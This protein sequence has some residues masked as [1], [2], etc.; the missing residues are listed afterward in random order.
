MIMVP[1]LSL[2]HRFI[3]DKA[4]FIAQRPVWVVQETPRGGGL[5]LSRKKD[6][7]TRNTYVGSSLDEKCSDLF[8]VLLHRKD[9]NRH[10]KK[11]AVENDREKALCAVLISIRCFCFLSIMKRVV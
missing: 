6:L 10:E 7:L 5:D 4:F 1:S 2:K 3:P 11:A 8:L 9:Q